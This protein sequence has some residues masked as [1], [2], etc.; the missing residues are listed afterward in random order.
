VPA[1]IEAAL[2]HGLYVFDPQ[3]DALL[4]PSGEKRPAS[5]KPLSPDVTWTRCGRPI[6][7]SEL[8]SED[9]ETGE[10]MHFD[11]LLDSLDEADSEPT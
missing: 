5:P 6:K 10:V 1:F 3:E 2:R 11:C 8:R 9:W 4:L 7:R